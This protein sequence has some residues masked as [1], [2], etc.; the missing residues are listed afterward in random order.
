MC[1]TVASV[2]EFFHSLKARF[3]DERNEGLAVSVEEVMQAVEEASA[4]LALLPAR[5]P[6]CIREGVYMWTAQRRQAMRTIVKGLVGRYA[7]FM[8][9]GG[10][11]YAVCDIP[12]AGKTCTLRLLAVVLPLM[13]STVWQC[14]KGHHDSV[15][16]V[17][18]LVDLSDR[19][20]LP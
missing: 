20:V 19:V 5:H 14:T 16:R 2:T 13:L 6:L 17:H 18:V 4:F 9:V 7:G 10:G 8:G 3:S 12:G 11:S 1:R 15:T